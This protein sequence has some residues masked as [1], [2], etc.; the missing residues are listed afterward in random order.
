[1]SHDPTVVL[2]P[3]VK[4]DH[5]D[6]QSNVQSSYL[7]HTSTTYFFSSVLSLSFCFVTY[8]VICYFLC[9]R[10]LCADS[11]M[12][13][14]VWTLVGVNSMKLWIWSAKRYKC[15]IWGP[16]DLF[17]PVCKSNLQ[18]GWGP[19]SPDWHPLVNIVIPYSEKFFLIVIKFKLIWQKILCQLSWSSTDPITNSETMHPNFP[20]TFFTS[21]VCYFQEPSG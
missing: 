19:V 16:Y 9:F 20:W 3:L 13:F 17:L 6:L 8:C 21:L 11:T 2:G 12:V 4:Q 18:K 10:I 15:V 14:L 7:L 5:V 1:M